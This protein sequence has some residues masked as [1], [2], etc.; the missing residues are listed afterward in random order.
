MGVMHGQSNIMASIMIVGA[1]VALATIFYVYY[2]G[3]LMRQTQLVPQPYAPV[4]I[5]DVYQK[6]TI[7]CLLV[8][9]PNETKL[10]LNNV[11]IVVSKDGLVIATVQ[12]PQIVLEPNTPTEVCVPLKIPERGWYDVALA[13]P[14]PSER[15]ALLMRTIFT[16]PNIVVVS[17]SYSP[18][19]AYDGDT[20]TFEANVCNLGELETNTFYT[21]FTVDGSEIARVP[22]DL[23][24]G[25]CTILK[26]TWSA[27]LGVHTVA[28]FADF[29]DEVN[30]PYETDNNMELT[31]VVYS[32]SIVVYFYH[33][34]P[35][36]D[37][38]NRYDGALF[39]GDYTHARVYIEG[40]PGT[41]TVTSSCL[42]DV[43]C[44]IDSN[45]WCE[46]TTTT[47][48]AAFSCPVSLVRD[49]T[50]VWSS[51]IPVHYLDFCD[52][53]DS[54]ASAFS[55]ALSRTDSNTI[56]MP[57]ADIGPINVPS[58]SYG[59]RV[60]LD[61]NDHSLGSL[62]FSGVSGLE[63]LEATVSSAS[64][65]LTLTSSSVSLK[66]VTLSAPTYLSM[67]ETSYIA[68]A[69]NA[70]C[71][72]YPI[73]AFGPADAGKNVTLG[74]VCHV[75]V[76]DTSSI[77][78]SGGSIGG[79]FVTTALAIVNASDIYVNNTTLSATDI[80]LNAR[81]SSNV[82]LQDVSVKG[83]NGIAR[84]LLP[85]TALRPIKVVFSG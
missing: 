64:T 55:L 4:K 48:S 30:E 38:S 41:Y 51:N 14:Y 26:A 11:P 67:D 16:P 78:L 21:Q 6:G 53:N 77:T 33:D 80:A 23:N 32:P 79:S 20:V 46:V 52:S 1:V 71:S 73:L 70:Y 61:A 19:P 69:E 63:I 62:S 81:T 59:G 72:T 7:L 37:P 39:F 75:S 49:G 18:E 54:C 28:V 15:R 42:N 66:D 44:V 56:V 10:E 58:G 40:P 22:A 45:Y 13:G 85:S 50:T 2:S 68:S 27:T 82:W 24:G 31:F 25:E 84:I 36:S 47:T 57:T 29:N 8:V 60:S 34:L 5:V 43:N 17:L 76:H 65:A 12:T 35:L 83:W 9:N 3:L 74:T